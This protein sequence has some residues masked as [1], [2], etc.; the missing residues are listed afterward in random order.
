[1]RGARLLAVVGA[2]LLSRSARADQTLVLDGPL[3][4]STAEF[5][6]LP[7]DVP[8]GTAEIEVRHDDLSEANILDW[9]LLEPGGAFRGW[10]GGNAEPAVV[11]LSAASR[12]YLAG[13]VAAGQWQVV[14][15]KAKIKE[16]PADYHV[17]IDLRDAATLAPQPE[18]AP[19]VAA[20]ALVT[21]ARWF[22]G[23]FHAH[24]RE[25]GDAK[26]TLDAMADFAAGRGLD[27]VH[28]SDHNTTAQLDFLV[29]VQGRHPDV[30][31]L[32]GVEFTTY[33][34][35]AGGIGATQWVDHK[36]GFGG[37]TIEG[38][39]DAFHAQ[40][41]LFSI[42]HPALSL[43][44]A[45]IGCGWDLPLGEARVDAVEIATTGWDAAGQL[46]TDDAIAFWD[47]I[48]D[49]GVHAAALG[50]SD[51][52]NAG[53]DEGPFG[54]PI[55]DPTTMVLAEEL[56]VGALVDAIRKGRTVVKLQGPADPM[57]ELSAEP[58]PEGDT[59]EARSVTFR[60]KVTGGVG[61]SVRFV[62]D[63]KPLD[64]VAI[65]SD[66]FE[67]A[68]AADAPSTGEDRWRVE[69]LVDDHPITVTSHLWVVSPGGGAT[70]TPAAPTA[71]GV[72]GGGCSCAARPSAESAPARA[73]L[74]LAAL[75]AAR[76]R[77]RRRGAVAAV[78]G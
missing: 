71:R 76:R 34:G 50:G 65:T 36:I 32:P 46:F 24:S 54:S 55:G 28:V 5:V 19:Y 35:H 40:G 14:V 61:G 17:E 11:G 70:P 20:G 60:A 33:H 68:V 43:G 66:P 59:V 42:N 77:R 73:A 26:P 9:G 44:S 22:A 10:G 4:D 6:L 2:V 39:I 62:H 48:C 41:A 8:A 56:S 51:D 52:H 23:D 3:E 47:S 37:V 7:F 78:P 74:A 63:G 57:A 45:C 21:G 18:R 27:F 64:A 29:D 1:M 12:S 67:H 13:P 58:A 31:L 69:V 30:L 25:S 15:G 49:T 53:V 72:E 75:F 38:A 16:T